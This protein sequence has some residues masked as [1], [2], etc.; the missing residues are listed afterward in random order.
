MVLGGIAIGGLFAGAASISHLPPRQNSYIKSII[1]QNFYYL[2]IPDITIEK[3]SNDF[4][5]TTQT[6]NN[7]STRAL[8][9]FGVTISHFRRF[10][11]SKNLINKINNKESFILSQFL[12]STNF[13][14]SENLSAEINYVGINNPYINGC[15]NKFA[16]LA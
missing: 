11:I 9:F 13:F 6:M 10:I 2:N 15:R 16:T 7:W 14:P 12:L 1:L 5:Q 8:L 4:I 3:F